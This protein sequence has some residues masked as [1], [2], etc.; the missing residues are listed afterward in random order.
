MM[1]SSISIVF[2]SYLTTYNY[3]GF[4]SKLDKLN[5]CLNILTLFLCIFSLFL[6]SLCEIRHKKIQFEHIVPK[7]E[8]S[9]Q[10]ENIENLENVK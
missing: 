6:L 10:I 7:T 8:N 2:G 1:S 4:T 3:F 5:Y 9:I